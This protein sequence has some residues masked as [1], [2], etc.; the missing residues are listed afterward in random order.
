MFVFKFFNSFC[1]HKELRL[2][3]MF[4]ILCVILSDTRIVSLVTRF[5]C[6]S[7][8]IL[9]HTRVYA[10]AHFL[11]ITILSNCRKRDNLLLIFFFC[12]SLQVTDCQMLVVI[13]HFGINT[14]STCIFKLRK[15]ISEKISV[16]LNKSKLYGLCCK[17]HL[18][19][20][21]FKSSIYGTK[22]V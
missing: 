9:V 10:A 21:E 19:N 1:Y 11:L 18:S 5:V 15:L 13:W 7:V 22:R 20:T 16:I 2:Y 17:R 3:K 12:I 4:A 14:H 6:S 8:Y